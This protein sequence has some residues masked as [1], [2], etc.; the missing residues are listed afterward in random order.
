M[1]HAVRW[2][3]V[4][5]AAAVFSLASLVYTFPLI[6]APAHA[7]RLDSPDALLNS[8]IISWNV[9][10]LRADPL[11]LFDA[12]IFFPEKGT[13]AY[14]ENLVTGALIAAPVAALT[15][16]ANANANPNPIVAFNTVLLVAFVLTGVATFV[17][18]YDLTGDRLASILAG[19]L[20]AFAPYRFAHIPHL[21]LQ[22]AFGIPLSLLFIRRLVMSTASTASTASTSTTSGTSAIYAAVGFALSAALT[23]GSSVYYAVFV[24]SVAP[25]VALTEIYWLP[26]RRRLAAIG[27][28]FLA[29]AG[30]I[31]L[32]L[33]LA[34]PYLDKLQGGTVRSLEAASSYSAGVTE[35]VSSFS[36]VHAFLPKAAEPLFP[37]FVALGLAAAALIGVSPEGTRKRCWALVGVIGVVLS[38]G[39]ALGL[40]SFLYRIAAPYRALRVPSRAGVLL[41]L[42]VAVLAALGLTLVRKKAFRWAL[43]AIAAVECMAAPL[44]LRLD[45]P[46]YPPIY[47]DVEALAE[48]GALVELPL[49]PPERFQDNALFVYRS[50]YHRRELVN[51]Y[52]GFVPRSYRRAHRLLMRRNFTRGL[53]SMWQDGVR[54]VLVHEGRLGP[55]MLRQIQQARDSGAL[56]MVSERAPDRLYAIAALR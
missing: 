56:V 22:L 21:Q 54:F 9:R 28:L 40:F 20:F 53:E 1:A 10:Q 39:P 24:A 33:P 43:V 37:G 52:S 45:V 42:A 38:A 30:A 15:N 12:N 25:L 36:R 35:Y 11:H 49:P 50:I 17:L 34:L 6:T 47:I 13:L 44:P 27:R 8:W 32:T 19:V 55:R 3:D 16:Y 14:S 4:L 29:G 5:L 23:F 51:G 48:P 31:V 2:K 18:A 46:T 26:R 7:N 41:L